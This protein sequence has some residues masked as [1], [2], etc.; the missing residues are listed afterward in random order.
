M[1]GLIWNQWGN[2]RIIYQICK[3]FVIFILD[4]RPVITRH[5]AI[6]RANVR[7]MGYRGFAEESSAE[8][9]MVLR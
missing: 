6:R 7:G 3:Y 5:E 1:P 4:A 8:L 9:M 2:I